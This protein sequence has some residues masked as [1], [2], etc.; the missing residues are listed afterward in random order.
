MEDI[1]RRLDLLELELE[2]LRKVDVGGAATS[3][4]PT[5]LGATSAGVTTYTTQLGIY[6]QF[7]S[8]VIATG[9]LTWTN[10]T[11]TGVA[12]I[13]GLPATSVNTTNLR[14]PIIG[15]YSAITFG[16]SFV[17]AL[18]AENASAFTMYTTTTNANAT[19]LNIEVA[20]DLAFTLVYF[21]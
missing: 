19:Q 6:A 4:T 7:G 16:G 11:G 15:W 5:Y 20:G 13:G 1:Y 18:L 2:R 14:Y 9:R 21:V 10:A 17:E 3:F 12:V 8:V